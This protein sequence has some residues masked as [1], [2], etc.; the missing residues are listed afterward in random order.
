ML[1]KSNK[2]LSET[3]SG[4]AALDGIDVG[5]EDIQADR[6]STVINA[7]VRRPRVVK[8]VCVMLEQT[9]DAK[10]YSTF[11]E[12]GPEYDQPAIAAPRQRYVI[13]S[14]QRTGSNVI[15]A[16]LIN[17]GA[18]G[19]PGEY[20]HP[21]VIQTIAKRTPDFAPNTKQLPLRDYLAQVAR[22]RST[23]NGVFGIK[24][25]PYQL[26]PRFK[27]NL[28]R[29]AAFL[30]EFDQVVFLRRNNLLR[31][32]ISGSIGQITKKWRNYGEEH[33]LPQMPDEQMT[34]I[35]SQVL[36]QYLKD[37]LL[38]QGVMAKVTAPKIT[39]SYEDFLAEPDGFIAGLRDFLGGHADR[40][41]K[42]PLEGPKK[43]PSDQARKIQETY[44]RYIQGQ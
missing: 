5:P 20:M 39:R 34:F 37:D 9:N 35:V 15:C 17:A 21:R 7:I 6:P 8:F 27:N 29:T 24:V 22:I 2:V 10:K 26:F 25:Q 11:L 16:A 36:T 33:D 4:N 38:M 1:R 12:E 41:V 18:F 13:F 32:A 31:Q 44:L 43:P 14:Q 40:P 30:S 19:V 3:V 23:D 42:L 28:D